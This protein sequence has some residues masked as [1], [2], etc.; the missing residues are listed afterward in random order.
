MGAGE[1]GGE[2]L[3]EQI[4]ACQE[5]TRFAEHFD[6]P[7]SE[8]R[9]TPLSPPAAMRHRAAGRSHTPPLPSPLRHTR[10]RTRAH[11]WGAVLRRPC[12]RRTPPPRPP[13]SPPPPPR[14]PASAEV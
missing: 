2:N 9:P 3:E 12:G 13:F 6:A 11:D 5:L 4:A 14:L 10:A 7:P 8:V 1:L